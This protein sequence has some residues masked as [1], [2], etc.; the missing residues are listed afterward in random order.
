VSTSVLNLD[1]EQHR[2]YLTAFAAGV[3]M[4]MLPT[5]EQLLDYWVVC[6]VPGGPEYDLNFWLDL[7]TPAITVFS[8]K[9]VSGEKY[10]TANTSGPTAQLFPEDALKAWLEQAR[11]DGYGHRD[12]AR[13]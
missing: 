4:A 5:S 11:K 3:V 2:P 9:A 8:T 12:D 6:Q 10:R 1:I 7:D 13:M